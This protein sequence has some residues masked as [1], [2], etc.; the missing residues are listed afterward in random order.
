[1]PPLPSVPGVVQIVIKG[2]LSGTH[3]WVNKLY[4]SYGGAAP[5]AVDLQAYATNLAATWAASLSALQSVATTLVEVEATDLSS[6]L[7]AVGILA[8]ATPGTRAGGEL[9]GSTA[10]LISYHATRHYR[11]GHPRT[12]LVGG[13]TTD[14]LT[15]S[16]W[17]PAFVTA[18]D[19]GIA[20]LI[21]AMLT[22]FGGFNPT[23]HV[24]V[25]YYGGAPPVLRR[26]V[27]RLVPIVDVLIAA[28]RTVQ[29]GVASQRRRIGRG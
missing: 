12:Y 6:P 29:T 15:Q 4:V 26:S 19:A 28:N 8:V 7:G 23:N 13:V 18:V 14:L 1:M 20:A 27:R 5:T 2:N 17:Q 11:G 25:S 10:V 21:V 16:T 24:N 9:A 22:P 3:Q